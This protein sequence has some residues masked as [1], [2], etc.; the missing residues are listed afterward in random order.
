MSIAPLSEALQQV[1]ARLDASGLPWCV[2]AGAAATCYGVQRTITDIDIALHSEDTARI[3]ALFPEGQ[4]KPTKHPGEYGLD[5]GQVE[6]WWGTLFLRGSERLY[7]VPF[8]EPMRARVTRQNILGINVPVSAPEDIIVL[9]AI[10][11][12]GPEQGK[13]DLEDIQAIAQTLGNRLDLDYL[14]ERARSCGAQERVAF[15]LQRLALS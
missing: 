12:R 15:C 8:D 13:H 7:S 9:K 14:K 10:L 11:Q 4:P 3:L 6:I 1:A 2:F 5:F